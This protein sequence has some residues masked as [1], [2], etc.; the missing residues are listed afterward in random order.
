MARP[1][2]NAAA[3][4]VADRRAA[5]RGRPADARRARRLRRGD[6][7]GSAHD[8]RRARLA[9][10]GQVRR[11]DWRI[12]SLTLAWIFRYL[13]DWTR[14]RRVV[15]W[16]TAS[17]FVLEVAI[18][19]AQAWRGTTSHFNV[20]T[21]LD[22]TLFSIMGGAIVLQT[23]ASVAVAVALWRQ[24]FAH[25]ALGWALRLGMTL[26]IIGAASGGLMTRPTD[27]QL[28][29]ARAG[30]G[31]AIAGA[32]TVGAPDGGPGLPGTGWS[33]E[34][35]DLRV[36]HFL[37]LHAVQVLPLLTLLVGRRLSWPDVARVRL[38]IV[39]GT[40]YGAAV[41]DPGLAGA[42]R[43]V[44]PRAGRR[45]AD[46]AGGVGVRDGRRDG[47]RH[48]FA[49][50]LQRR[51]RLLRVNMSA[52]QIF[53]LLNAIAL[54][55]WL[56]IAVFP[57]RP[58]VVQTIAGT[59]IPAF[60]AAAYI[61]M[62]ASAWGGSEGSF[63]SLQGV[64]ALFENPW[65]LLAGWTHYL[66][67]DL[68][69][70]VWEV[71]DCVDARHPARDGAAVSAADLPVRP[72][73]LAALSCSAPSAIAVLITGHRSMRTHAD[74]ASFQ[75]TGRGGTGFAPRRYRQ[76]PMG[77]AMRL[78]AAVPIGALVCVCLASPSFAQDRRSSIQGFGG[79]RVGDFTS[80]DTSFGGVITSELTPYIHVVGEAGRIGNVLSPTIDLALGF[81]PGDFGFATSAW[82]GQGGV[83]LMTARSGVKPYV[84]T[85]AGIARLQT[86]IDGLGAGRTDLLTNAA[87]QFLDGTIADGDRRRRHH[88]RRRPVSDRHRLSLSTI[89]LRQLGECPVVRAADGSQRGSHRRRRPLLILPR[90]SAPRTPP[91]ALSRAASPARSVRVARSR[92]RSRSCSVLSRAGPLDPPPRRGVSRRERSRL[93][94]RAAAGRRRWPLGRE[95]AAY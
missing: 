86:R 39:A 28:A 34:H 19:A 84:E 67:F 75:R 71:R 49:R 21:P 48:P 91:H 79:L 24:R 46:G 50:G 3:R 22:A 76:R 82:Y 25:E 30:L 10:A 42:Q 1:P 31:M 74:H 23:L 63:S 17:I 66:A 77:F 61:A 94:C 35:G 8:H 4:P 15:G 85:Q 70:G 73:R 5:H 95:G 44:D 6:V 52:E 64:A 20:G 9:E 88:V 32:H 18:I 27:A 55:A 16:S 7:A 51:A 38:V 80:N 2:S 13:P 65:L 43:A 89:L 90:G 92:A 81:I 33:V 14:T 54:V 41:R 29:D 40:S 68:L 78:T 69:V 58:L 37:G 62:I 53:S 56:L 47:G 57:R 45:H 87:L 12:F 72:D 11:L 60:F 59:V 93:R 36:P 26:T 83:R